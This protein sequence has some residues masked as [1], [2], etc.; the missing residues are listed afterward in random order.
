MKR[1]LHMVQIHL[2]V[3]KYQTFMVYF[4]VDFYLIHLNILMLNHVIQVLLHQWIINFLTC[5]CLYWFF[6][7]H[8]KINCHLLI[9]WFFCALLNFDYKTSHSSSYLLT[10]LKLYVFSHPLYIYISFIQAFFHE[11]SFLKHFLKFWN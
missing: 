4:F 1:K 6:N 2:L 8:K 5:Y 11:T 3:D 7:H 9:P 10:M